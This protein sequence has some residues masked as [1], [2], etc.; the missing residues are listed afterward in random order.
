MP[1]IASTKVSV[2]FHSLNVCPT[3]GI[4]FAICKLT[5]HGSNSLLFAHT[6]FQAFV[7]LN[8]A[9]QYSSNISISSMDKIIFFPLQTFLP[10]STIQAWLFP[11]LWSTPC[12]PSSKILHQIPYGRSTTDCHQIPCSEQAQVRLQSHPNNPTITPLDDQCPPVILQMNQTFYLNR[13]N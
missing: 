2:I 13:S 4:L 1:N 3:T 8:K 12:C 10:K 7:S 6:L 5:T 9:P 11:Y